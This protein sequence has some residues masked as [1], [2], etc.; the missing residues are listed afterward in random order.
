[1]ALRTFLA[2]EVSAG[3]A[4]RIGGRL[5]GERVLIPIL[6]L[7]ESVLTDQVRVGMTLARATNGRVRIV[8]PVGEGP[9]GHW[10]RTPRT[11]QGATVDA[12]AWTQERLEILRD[13][14]SMG[15]FA[16]RR[17]ERRI[18]ETVANEPWDTLVLPAKDTPSSLASRPLRRLTERPPCDVISINGETAFRDFASILLPIANGP[19]SGL[20]TDV[21]AAIAYDLDAELDVLHVIDPD[22]DAEVRSTAERRI[23][24]AVDRTGLSEGVSPWLLEATDPSRSIV[25]QSNYYGLTVIGAP[26][27]SRLHQFVYGS[28]SR[29]IRDRAESA[30]LATRTAHNP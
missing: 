23:D 9:D 13:N 21:A 6:G 2:N 11:D 27:A 28:T 17:I 1:M 30:V 25:E 24:T 12:L 8:D 15:L 18:R 26:T 3:D 4:V 20:A 5:E 16:S 19:H 10:D 29:V 7:N 14:G 22:A